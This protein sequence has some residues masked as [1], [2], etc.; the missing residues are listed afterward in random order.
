[1]GFLD[2]VSRWFKREA[3]EARQSVAALEERLD[4]DLTRRERELQATAEERI[5]MIR[6]DTGAEDTLAEIQ[7]R[8]D[9]AQAHA[10]AT[11][12]LDDP[13]PE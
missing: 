4:A 9:R 10:D 1:M 12:E 2:S 13:P 8:I 5:E 6:S 3:A 11:A 7:A